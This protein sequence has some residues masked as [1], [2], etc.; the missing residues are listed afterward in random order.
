MSRYVIE[1]GLIYTY[2]YMYIRWLHMWSYLTTFGVFVC[3]MNSFHRQGVNGVHNPRSIPPSCDLYPEEYAAFVTSIKEL[4][5]Q[6]RVLRCHHAHWLC[7]TVF[8]KIRSNIIARQA[9]RNVTAVTTP[10]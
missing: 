6:Y 1:V 5:E 7:G 4:A 9:Q 3:C 10:N 2:A 8:P